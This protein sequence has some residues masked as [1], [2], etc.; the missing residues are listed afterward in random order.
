LGIAG[1]LFAYQALA[2][3]A[4]NMTLLA[5]AVVSWQKARVLFRSISEEPTP[6]VPARRPK[7]TPGKAVLQ[8]LGVC[9][10]YAPGT[11]MVLNGCDLTIRSGDRILLEG[12]SGSG[13]STLM[14]LLAGLQ[15]PT[16]GLLLLDGLDHFSV[17]MPGWRRR[18]VAAPQF[19]E[20]H[21]LAE[22]LAFNLLLGRSWPPA[23]GDLADAEAVC[24]ELGLAP[25]LERMPA[26][27]H[28]MVGDSGWQLSHGEK[29]R[30]YIARALLQRAEIVVLDESFAALDPETLVQ[31]L[32]CVQRRATT[33]VVIAHP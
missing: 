15:Q 1:L 24:S 12:H 11:P 10:R 7:S 18:V 2:K 27:L 25:L 26:G 8:A 19:H 33:L 4:P 13:K 21:I 28:Q 6:M 31:A 22:S 9:F 17:G 16:A 23:P 29:S 30:V 32:Q 3:L 14:S 5:S 20:N